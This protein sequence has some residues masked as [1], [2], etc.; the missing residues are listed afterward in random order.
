MRISDWSSDVCSSDLVQT[1]QT[2]ALPQDG[3][4]GAK[5]ELVG[6]RGKLG[7]GTGMGTEESEGQSGGGAPGA[8]VDYKAQ[9]YAWL[10][11][12]KEYPRRARLR[13]QE[14]T[15]LLELDRKSVVSGKSVAVRVDPGGRR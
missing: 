8:F 7:A 4:A 10:D 3:A 6:N 14:G 9:L 11:K 12:H 5:D 1:T 15:A 2:A 13:R